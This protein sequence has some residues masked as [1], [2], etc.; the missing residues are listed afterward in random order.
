MSGAGRTTAA[1]VLE[2]LGWLV[3]DNLPPQMLAPLADLRDACHASATPRPRHAAVAV[4]VDVRSRGWFG[5]SPE[6]IDAATRPGRATE[7][8]SSSTRPTRRSSAA[9]RA[10][11]G[12]TRCRAGDA[13]STASSGSVAAPRPALERR[14]RHRHLRAQR[15]PAGGEAHVP[16]RRRPEGPAA[17]RRDVLRV[18]V[19]PA[20]RRR[21]RLRHAVPAQPVLGARAQAAHRPRRAGGRVRHGRRPVPE[22]SSTG[23]ATCSRP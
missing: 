20:A 12:R 19:R 11:A 2:D 14:R 4:V 16:L 9:S 1:N 8:R 3:V 22:S 18:Q 10:S 13:S 5:T 23:R 6:A 17:D 15:P 21:R 7:P